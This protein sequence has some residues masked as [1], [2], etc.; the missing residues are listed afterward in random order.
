[1]FISFCSN[2][3]DKT[4]NGGNNDVPTLP[5]FSKRILMLGQS[6]MAGWFDHWADSSHVVK[7]GYELFYGEMES[8]PDIVVSA[9]NRIN[10]RNIEL[11]A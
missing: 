7:N 10:Q 8:P 5:A 11:F 6:V 1:M 4:G 3:N 2:D 9:I